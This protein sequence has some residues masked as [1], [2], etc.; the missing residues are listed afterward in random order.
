MHDLTKQLLLELIAREVPHDMGRYTE[1]PTEQYLDVDMRV[2]RTGMQW[3]QIRDKLCWGA[4]YYH[5]KKWTRYD[6]FKKA[7]YYLT[8]TKQFLKSLGKTFFIDSC[9]LANKHGFVGDKVSRS[10]KHK[11]KNGTKITVIVDNNGMPVSLHFS[12]A[13][14]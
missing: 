8:R 9:I 3:K 11:F 2:L 6:I 4:Y 10:Y 1:Y 5:F 12:G 7:F 13:K 14:E